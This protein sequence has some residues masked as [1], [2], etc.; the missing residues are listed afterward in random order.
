VEVAEVIT[1]VTDLT[2]TLEA[3][4]QVM[5][6]KTEVDLVEVAE[7]TT[8]NLSAQVVAEAELQ[9]QALMQDVQL[10]QMELDHLLVKEDS[11][12]VLEH[13]AVDAVHLTTGPHG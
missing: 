2:E 12:G 7:L 8:D 9:T 4:E 11:V 1:K 10:P 13:L 6:I 3:W 5:E